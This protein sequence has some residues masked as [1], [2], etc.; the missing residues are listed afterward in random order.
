V[1]NRVFRRLGS[2]PS[3]KL[4][5]DITAQAVMTIGARMMRPWKKYCNRGLSLFIM[6]VK[7]VHYRGGR[8]VKSAFLEEKI[9]AG[10]R[11]QVAGSSM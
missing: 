7:I 8:T 9:A 6:A 10:C 5:S 4:N 11:W 3:M 2:I 1:G